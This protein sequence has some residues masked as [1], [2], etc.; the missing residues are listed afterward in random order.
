MK[1][2]KNTLIIIFVFACIQAKAQDYK[3][4]S[5]FMY[6]F[7]KYIQWPANYQTGDFIIGVLG[8]SPIIEQLTKMAESKTVG[9]QKFNIVKFANPESIEKCHMLFIPGNKSNDLDKVLSQ[10]EGLST[11]IITEKPGLGK[12][13]S[14]INF[15]IVDGKWKFELNK[16]STDKSKLKVS[17]ELARLAIEL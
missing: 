17:G 6:N 3:F 9:N 16:A 8:D 12:K 1:A 4:H 15:I 10:T 11:L 13:G 7:T 5:V 14:A 2:L